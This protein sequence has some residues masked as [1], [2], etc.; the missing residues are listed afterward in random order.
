MQF[1]RNA[2]QRRL[3][4]LTR[5]IIPGST[6]GSSIDNVQQHQQRSALLTLQRQQ[7]TASDGGMFAGQVV[8]ITGQGN[9]VVHHELAGDIGSYALPQ[10]V[11]ESPEM[12]RA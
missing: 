11:L 6:S 1:E 5:H 3:D 10:V 8:V 12:L 2:G 4:V 9:A 7:T